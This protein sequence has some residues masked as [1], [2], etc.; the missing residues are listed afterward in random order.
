MLLGQLGHAKADRHGHR[1]PAAFGVHQ[2][3]W[4]LG[5]QL[6]QPLRHLERLGSGHLGQHDGD[7]LAAQPARVVHGAQV[8]PEQAGE[9][10]ED[11][12]TRRMAVGVVHFLEVVDVE[13]HQGHRGA[14]AAAAGDFVAQQPEQLAPVGEAGQLVGGGEGADRLEGASPLHRIAQRALEQG[15]IQPHLGYE[16]HGAGPECRLVHR[17]VVIAGEHDERH[18]A[19]GPRGR[20]HQVDAIVGPQPVV[21]QRHVMIVLQQPL[22]ARLGRGH[23]VQQVAVAAGIAQQVADD[24]I[25]L[26]IVVDHEDAKRLLGAERGEAGGGAAER[27]LAPAVRGPHAGLLTLASGCAAGLLNRE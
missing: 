11:R 6:A 27:L 24:E 19:A 22:Q 10:L 3:A 9:P 21:D 7:L 14:V 20:I 16:V 4:R 2:L 23:P 13:Q 18:P 8:V 12:V 15:A 25:I 1:D 17:G 26:L 5:H